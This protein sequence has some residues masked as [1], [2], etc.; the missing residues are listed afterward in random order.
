MTP[1][2]AG[3]RGHDLASSVNGIASFRWT[4][5]ESVSGAPKLFPYVYLASFLFALLC[6]CKPA[7]RCDLLPDVD[8]KK[9]LKKA[10]RGR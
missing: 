9:T 8:L 3:V 4:T 1:T 6:G 10:G 5:W 7:P 2:Y